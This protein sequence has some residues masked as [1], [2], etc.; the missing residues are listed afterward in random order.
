[1]RILF[2]SFSVIGVGVY[3]VLSRLDRILEFLHSVPGVSQVLVWVI[4]AF[5]VKVCEELD[6][7]QYPITKWCNL[8]IVGGPARCTGS[9]W[10][11]TPVTTFQWTC[12]T[13][14]KCCAVRVVYTI[15]G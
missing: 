13:S 6:V 4:P 3:P 12:T 8:F 10:I 9:L 5:P 1:M 11:V 7:N 15:Q 2:S 14:A